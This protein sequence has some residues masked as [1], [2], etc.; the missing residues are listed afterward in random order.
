MNL[1]N[2]DM[3]EIEI[4]TL[5][6]KKSAFSKVEVKLIYETGIEIKASMTCLHSPKSELKAQCHI[7]D[8]LGFTD[9][10]IRDLSHE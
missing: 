1:E 7:L 9:I 4:L 6:S 5:R 8:S 2:I 10:Q 3:N